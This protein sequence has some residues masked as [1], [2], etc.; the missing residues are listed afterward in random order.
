LETWGVR[1]DE[2]KLQT[3]RIDAVACWGP[4]HGPLVVLNPQG[5]HAKNEAGRRATLAHELCHL[6][7][8]RHE[9]LPL[10]EAA[11]G[12]VAPDL[13]ARARAF[14]AEF[15]APRSAS[16]ERW[17]RGV[18]SL[19]ARLKSLCRHFGVSAQLAA[20]QL[21]NS[22]RLLTEPEQAF[23]ERQAQPQR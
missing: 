17:S 21:L 1:V 3:D 12:Q 9:A 10:A 20:W 14:A 18:G 16:F 4:N 19:E 7:I 6:L 23:L 11:G 13:E 5:T 22:G 2:V 8:D 15:L